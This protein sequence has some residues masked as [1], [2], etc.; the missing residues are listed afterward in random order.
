[1]SYDLQLGLINMD[2]PYLHLHKGA[3]EQGSVYTHWVSMHE[4]GWTM[5]TGRP[6]AKDPVVAMRLS[7]PVNDAGDGENG[8]HQDVVGTALVYGTPSYQGQ[9]T[10]PSAAV[11]TDNGRRRPNLSG[12][13]IGC[14]CSGGVPTMLCGSR[15]D[16]WVTM[17]D[18]FC[19][20]EAFWTFLNSVLSGLVG[21][22]EFLKG[23]MHP[24]MYQRYKRMD[25]VLA[26]PHGPLSGMVLAN[27][28]SVLATRAGPAASIFD[29]SDW[30]APLWLR[31]RQRMV[32][33]MSRGGI[34]EDADAP[35]SGCNCSFCAGAGG[36]AS[37]SANVSG[38]FKFGWWDWARS[39]SRLHE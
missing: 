11:S 9:S 15:P 5:A 39:L 25:T 29:I 28:T 33:S 13:T 19:S 4:M 1:M 21:R 7:R 31:I 2:R 27:T 12:D 35:V 17:R 8:T 23:D 3:M 30:S 38:T 32:M 20:D 36:A 14:P 24:S 6:V 16:R 34:G 26:A 37:G 10:S 22:A 18:A